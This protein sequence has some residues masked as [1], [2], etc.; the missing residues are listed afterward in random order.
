MSR[1]HDPTVIAVDL[2]S[3]SA[4]GAAFDTEGRAS[5]VI[6][7][8]T[9]GSIDDEGEVALMPYQKALIS[10]VT[11]L[12]DFHSRTT[13]IGITGMGPSLVL[14]HRGDLPDMGRSYRYGRDLVTYGIDAVENSSI[15]SK[16]GIIPGP[17]YTPEQLIE[18]TLRGEPLDNITPTSFSAAI[19]SA[20]DR[21][22]LESIAISSASYMG[23]VDAESATY[24]KELETGF[25][26]P[27]SMFPQLTNG[28]S[29]TIR[30][31]DNEQPTGI[32]ELGTDGPNSH[33]TLKTDAATLKFETT[34]AARITSFSPLSGVP[35]NI[36]HVDA[37][38]KKSFVAGSSTNSG[39]GT[40]QLYF[41]PDTQYAEFEPGLQDIL[42]D[43]KI[44]E[45][46]PIELPFELGERDGLRQSG[47]FYGQDLSPASAPQDQRHLYYALTEGVLFNMLQL[48]GRVRNAKIGVG[49]QP[50]NLFILTGVLEKNATIRS[51][52]HIMFEELS[53]IENVRF[54]APELPELGLTTAA[55]ATFAKEGR[56]ESIPRVAEVKID[57]QIP[58][59]TIEVIRNRWDLYQRA[60]QQST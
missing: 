7:V 2:G 27:M 4:K 50:S 13:A 43:H 47:G 51:L 38:G 33:H 20:L 48:V 35:W 31:P 23:L 41:P 39:V 40:W 56:R 12:A 16:R 45:T 10:I 11:S 6:S 24:I 42:G 3:T 26:L 18:M 22:V 32:Y 9:E 25:G 29:A 55:V 30:L 8:N 57:H 49:E 21:R 1:E 37:E 44:I 60:Y 54:L 46:L 53:G 17:Q 5:D 19:A 15:P 28:L 14:V 52:L 59:S 34:L 36:L 58:Q